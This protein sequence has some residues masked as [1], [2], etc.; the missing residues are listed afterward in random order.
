[1]ANIFYDCSY[2]DKNYMNKV[3]DYK[4]FQKWWE[5]N[6]K[7]LLKAGGDPNSIIEYFPDELIH[8]MVRNDL[9]IVYKG[10]IKDEY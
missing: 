9:Y 5:K 10:E 3:K 4:L 2:K 1:M 8:L 7:E 6:S